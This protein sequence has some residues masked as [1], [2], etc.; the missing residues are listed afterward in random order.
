MKA[1]STNELL[2]PDDVVAYYERSEPETYD[3]QAARMLFLIRAVA[4]RINDTSTG[5]L[6]PFGL[7]ALSYHVLAR[8]QAAPTHAITLSVLARS[9]HTRAQTITS[10]INTL[11]SDGLVRRIA[12]AS[13]RRATL[14]RLTAKGLKI[15]AKAT[16]SQHALIAESMRG[17]GASDRTRV[18]S[19][20]SEIGET[21]SAEKSRLQRR[22]G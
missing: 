5:W 7:S 9:L 3:G 12:H 2:I 21:L 22:K 15:A 20:L 6:E 14:A 19:I 10:L 11:E 1:V 8:L 18:I 17:V 13:D 4:Q 16:R